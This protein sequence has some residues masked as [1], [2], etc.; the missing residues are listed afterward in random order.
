MATEQNYKNHRRY[1]P[2]VHFVIQPILTA[3]VVLEIMELFKNPSGRQAW[4]VLV[5]AAVLA[6]SFMARSMALAA[7]NRV[8][9][10]EER[11]RLATLLPADQRARI[12]DL[13]TRQLIGLR[14]ASDEEVAGLAQR[15]LAGELK[16][17][18]D[19]KKAVK[20]WRADHQRV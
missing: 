14:Y 20:N 3:N 15:C 13:T 9:R 1:L 5:W 2:I 6:F 12:N 4:Q 16:G 17:S 8:I 10:L 18:E 19:V 7:Q 11:L